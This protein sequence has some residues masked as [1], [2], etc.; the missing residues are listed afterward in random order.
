MRILSL[1]LVLVLLV[2][3][4]PAQALTNSDLNNGVQNNSLDLHNDHD[5]H[6]CEDHDHGHEDD[7]LTFSHDDTRR[8]YEAITIPPS[9]NGGIL[10]QDDYYTVEYE[11]DEDDAPSKSSAPSF[12]RGD[13]PLRNPGAPLNDEISISLGVY[14]LVR[15]SA[16][17]LPVTVN[18]DTSDFTSLS[19][20]LLVNG[21]KVGTTAV[22][23]GAAKIQLTA[24][25]LTIPAGF[26]DVCLEGDDEVLAT[27]TIELLVV[28]SNIFAPTVSRAPFGLT[29]VV[30]AD[31]VSIP[32]NADFLLDNLLSINGVFYDG[33]F[34][35]D[36][37]AVII[38][39]PYDDLING[40]TV[41]AA[42]IKF[43]RFY[44]AY[45]FT[46]SI[47]V[48]KPQIQVD[49][50][51][52]ELPQAIDEVLTAYSHIST[53][54]IRSQA[55]IDEV[56][57]LIADEIGDEAAVILEGTA[58]DDVIA[59]LYTQPEL[60]TLVGW[61]QSFSL[62]GSL[63][64]GDPDDDVSVVANQHNIFICGT[65]EGMN[66][67]ISYST[68]GSMTKTFAYY[69]DDIAYA[70]T[71][72]DNETFQKIDSSQR[73]FENSL[74]DAEFE[75]F[76]DDL[77]AGLVTPPET[78]E[79]ETP[80]YTIEFVREY[81]V[82]KNGES[83]VHPMLMSPSGNLQAPEYI[84][85]LGPLPPDDLAGE[86][87]CTDWEMHPISI[88]GSAVYTKNPSDIITI[89][90]CFSRFNLVEKRSA[91][92]IF[93]T[94]VTII[95]ISVTFGGILFT[96]VPTTVA[97]AIAMGY[98]IF[99]IVNEGIKLTESTGLP[100]E[101]DYT[102]TEIRDAK[103][104]DNTY[105]LGYVQ[106]EPR[107]VYQDI[108]MKLTTEDQQVFTYSSTKTDN[109]ANSPTARE[110]A[111]EVAEDFYLNCGTPPYRYWRHGANAFKG[112]GGGYEML[113]SHSC[114][115]PQGWQIHNDGQHKRTCMN[116]I[117]ATEYANHYY[118]DIC[119]KTCN[120]CGYVN[121]SRGH[122]P[123]ASATC[124]DDQICTV[125]GTPIIYAHG[126]SYGSATCGIAA[127][128]SWCGR[129]SGNPPE[130]DMAPATCSTPATCNIC[131]YSVGD[132]AAHF[133]NPAT[134]VLKKTCAKCGHT[135]GLAL[136]HSFGSPSSISG[137]KHEA[138]CTR[139]KSNVRA[140]PAPPAKGSQ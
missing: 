58:K 55:V 136:D 82:A 49:P 16:A 85:I 129:P 90:T 13:A 11:I 117:C 14:T 41:G 4:L 107:Y 35:E 81:L 118:T 89:H 57:E 130:H 139:V 111:E 38:D 110:Q 48:N 84:P 115:F 87:Y 46:F 74:T 40:D 104:Y 30:F 100:Q 5:H 108:N 66:Y 45:S 140:T 19:V 65:V 128:C 109:W 32:A 21:Q 39:Y 105:T 77:L 71:N 138:F 28:P 26:Y 119:D 137:A 94:G 37:M 42:K 25:N 121:Q 106:L 53:D 88:P 76:R 23:E 1:A 18:G 43:P 2:G 62:S 7:I 12:D 95:G 83:N 131:G 10:F 34:R 92:E 78:A 134:C 54:E 72:I 22:S 64:S 44:P 80:V 91:W 124:D 17:N 122:S 113:P 127:T 79:G 15:A 20:Y 3:V 102:V 60:P 51:S 75:E 33:W 114:I 125:C 93:Q 61:G 135:E 112:L 67:V 36:N 73:L 6:D 101:I 96:G 98:N 24:Q 31:I 29:Q 116:N 50:I 86:V 8:A 9:G 132:N 70:V 126:H 133:F 97:A 120:G 47:V 27:A 103:T 123:G 63:G 69:V 68:V 56:F 52:D 59:A 99:T